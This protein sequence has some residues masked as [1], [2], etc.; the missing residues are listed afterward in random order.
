[1]TWPLYSPLPSRHAALP[2]HGDLSSARDILRR[3]AEAL[4]SLAD[5]LDVSFSVAIDLLFACQGSVIVTGMGKAG[6]IGQKIAATL[7]S[8]GTNA[9]VLHPADAAH[10][11]LGRIHRDDLVLALS[12]SGETE[13]LVRLLPALAELH[14]PLVAM[15][16]HAASVLAQAANVVLDLGPLREACPHGLAPTT[17]TTAMLALGDALAIVL[18]Q[19]RGFSRADF[20][21]LHPGGSLGRRLHSGGGILPPSG[22]RRQDAAATIPTEH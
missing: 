17:S 3:E 8:T 13:E 11:D 12:F 4:L 21:R 18:S 1:M 15:T 14:V 5:R 2:K 20:A 22:S 9:H 7:A 19:R 6:L 16:G 10:G